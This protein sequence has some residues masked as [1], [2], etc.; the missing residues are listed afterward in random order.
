MSILFETCTVVLFL[1]VSLTLVHSAELNLRGMGLQMRNWC[2]RFYHVFNVL[3]YFPRFIFNVLNF[4]IYGLSVRLF[5]RLFVYLS[6]LK[7]V[8]KMRFSQ[9]LSNLVLWFS[10]TTNMK[11]YMHGFQRTRS[12]T[13]GM[14]FG[15]HFKVMLI[16]IRLFLLKKLRYLELRSQSTDGSGGLSCRPIWGDIVVT[17]KAAI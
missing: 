8:H 2:Q 14:T 13:H 3:K 16:V 6:R 15:S 10:F 12:C 9:K 1:Y 4:Y 11:S 5:L 7:R 17:D